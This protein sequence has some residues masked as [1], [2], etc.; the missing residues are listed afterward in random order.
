[1]SGAMQQVTQAVILFAYGAFFSQ[2]NAVEPVAGRV[3]KDQCS[4]FRCRAA[5]Q[6]KCIIFI[7][8]KVGDKIAGEVVA[9]VFSRPGQEVVPVEAV[10][11][12]GGGQPK[13]TGRVLPDPENVPVRKAVF[14]TVG[15]DTNFP[16]LALYTGKC[17]EQA[18]KQGYVVFYARHVAVVKISAG[19]K[20]ENATCQKVC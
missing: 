6:P 10:Q 15:P 16:R 20:Y 2:K 1:M 14:E 7:E 12:L 19:A 3:E 4:G 9:A 8:T 18:E 13:E 11:A 17:Q 5:R